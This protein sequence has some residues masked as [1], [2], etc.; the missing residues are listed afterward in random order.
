MK[1]FLFPALLFA[2]LACF[3]SCD[4]GNSD[5]EPIGKAVDIRYEFEFDGDF[6]LYTILL[7]FTDFTMDNDIADLQITVPSALQWTLTNDYG[8]SY[9]GPILANKLVVV[10]NEKI[11]QSS[12]TFSALLSNVEQEPGFDPLTAQIKVFADDKLVESYD[13]MWISDEDISN[14]VGGTIDFLYPD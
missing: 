14:G 2:I 4:D 10:S 8:T 12:F 6:E 3:S 7:I 5:D 13:Y 1:N 11:R 9:T